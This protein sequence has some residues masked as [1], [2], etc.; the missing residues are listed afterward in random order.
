MVPK[1]ARKAESIKQSLKDG[2]SDRFNVVGEGAHHGTRGRVRSP[3]RGVDPAELDRARLLR[4]A[5]ERATPLM[6]NPLPERFAIQTSA[7][8]D[9]VIG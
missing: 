3:F 7:D 2:P 4:I 5:K 9:R 8:P 1:R 6:R